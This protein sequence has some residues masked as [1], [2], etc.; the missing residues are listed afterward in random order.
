MA[1]YQS[2]GG[3]DA[4]LLERGNSTGN[5]SG[6]TD[7]NSS[8]VR[9]ADYVSVFREEAP[10][11][12]YAELVMTVLVFLA[13]LVTAILSVVRAAEDSSI[14]VFFGIAVVMMAVNVVTLVKW[15]REGDL[16]PKFKKL[17][18]YTAAVLIILCIAADV[19]FFHEKPRT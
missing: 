14:H 12:Y 1:G 4:S 7:A 10:R 9:W 11:E 13:V 2:M 15:Y 8:F 16:E 5:I 6:R 3:E 17:I 19:E 18:W